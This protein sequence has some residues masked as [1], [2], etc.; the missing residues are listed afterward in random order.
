[1]GLSKI[2]PEKE[3]RRSSETIFQRNNSEHQTT[4]ENIE[5]G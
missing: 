5:H 4:I 2:S 1:M 3:N